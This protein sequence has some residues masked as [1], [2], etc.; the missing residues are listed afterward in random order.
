M[1]QEQQQQPP[2]GTQSPPAKEPSPAPGTQVQKPPEQQQPPSIY[3]QAGVPEPGAPGSSTF[4]ENWRELIAGGDEKKLAILKRYEGFDKFGNAHFGLVQR[5]SSGEFKASKPK[6]TGANVDPEALKAWRAEQG[7]PDSVEVIKFPLME[8][9]KMEDLDAG[10]KSRVAAFTKAFFDNDLTQA[11]VDGLMGVYNQM[12]ASE[13]QAQATQDAKLADETED[14]L[15]ADFGTQFKPTILATKKF[16]SDTF[17][18]LADP[19]ALARL[20][21][22]RRIMDVPV[23]AKAF[24]SIA[25]LSGIDMNETGDGTAGKTVDARIAEIEGY[26]SEVGRPKYTPAVQAEYLQLL[27]RKDARGGR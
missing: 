4:P 5:I 20:P 13:L 11:Q 18:E 26:M 14:A 17:G 10:G 12:Q 21:D 8:G 3:S 27:E 25:R 2:T 16:L 6:P 22:G 15:R 7:L 1:P 24:A 19:L 9:V 23:I